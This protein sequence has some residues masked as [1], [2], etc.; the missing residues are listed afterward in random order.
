MTELRHPPLAVPGPLIHIGYHKTGTTW[1]QRY[2]FKDTG[3]GFSPTISHPTL[4]R[5]LWTPHALDF[6]AATCRS[7]FDPYLKIAREAGL[8]P[9]ISEEE[10]SGNPHVGGDMSKEIASRLHAT[11]PDGRVL[12]MI[13]EQRRMIRSVYAQY[14]RDTGVWSL[15]RYLDPPI[16]N[17]RV[18]YP[19]FRLEHFRYDRLIRWYIELFGRSNVLVLSYEQFRSDPR[20]LVASIVDFCGLSPSQA[21]LHALPYTSIVNRSLSGIGIEIKRRANG[22]FSER[23]P[24]LPYTIWPNRSLLNMIKIRSFS[25]EKVLPRHMLDASN[26]RLDRIIADR[27][28]GYYVESNRATAAMT[29]LDLAQWGYDLG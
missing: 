3:I 16:V 13:R 25:F 29:G 1:L 7:G 4:L 5:T 12:L 9:V 15:E 27:T 20:Q 21:Q 22:I 14:V 26:Q 18:Q 10:L 23:R 28:A 2:L 17:R 19:T 11:F 6:D 8:M 24:E